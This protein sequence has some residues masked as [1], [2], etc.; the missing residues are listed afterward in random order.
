MTFSIGAR[1]GFSYVAETQ[2]GVI[3]S[4]PAMQDLPIT[5]QNITLE[6]Q[7]ITSNS[8]RLDRQTDHIRHGQH[9]VTGT[10]EA[11]FYPN[12]FDALLQGAFMS[13]F[14]SGIMK[15]G[16]SLQSFTFEDRMS[17]I[18]LY[19]KFK[20]CIVDRFNLR[21][22]P[23]SFISASF[24]I[25]GVAQESNMT[26]ALD[27]SYSA[28]P[29][30]APFDSFQSVIKE[31]DSVIAKVTGLNL[32]I[33]NNLDSAYRIGALNA[34]QINIGRAKVSGEMTVYIDNPTLLQKFIDETETSLSLTCSNGTVTYEFIVPRLK[35]TA[36]AVNLNDDQARI[37]TLPFEALRDPT[38]QTMLQVTKS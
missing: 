10:I 6:K 12:I 2:F 3:P 36:G 38:S 17:D 33:D 21:I 15:I 14:S 35:F 27:N 9:Q 25:L 37:L 29:N 32:V 7:V 24:A 1:A 34:S 13:Q 18:A 16:T 11:E 4:S 5:G 26:T 20:G 28:V 23:N 31:N 19:R 22:Q 30:I 8:L